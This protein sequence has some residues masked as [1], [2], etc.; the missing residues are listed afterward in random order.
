MNV[1][2]AQRT[3]VKKVT[4]I[5]REGRTILNWLYSICDTWQYFGRYIYRDRFKIA[6][7]RYL[8]NICSSDRVSRINL[9]QQFLLSIKFILSEFILFY[10]M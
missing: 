8:Y 5:Y 1:N 7:L 9:L 10:K 3:A 2:Y 6:E 4:Y